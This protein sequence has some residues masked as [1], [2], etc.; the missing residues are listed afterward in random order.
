MD[1]GKF[2]MAREPPRE[3]EESHLPFPIYRQRLVLKS[4]P[5][6]STT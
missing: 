5:E 4:Q 2:Q 6:I 3:L 1:I